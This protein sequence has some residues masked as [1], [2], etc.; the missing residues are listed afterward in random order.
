MDPAWPSL[1]FQA[2]LLTQL[3]RPGHSVY[4]NAMGHESPVELWLRMMS[5]RLIKVP[6]YMCA[7]G[8]FTPLV[9]GCVFVWMCHG[10]G[11]ELDEI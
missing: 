6:M 3:S 8:V 9:C 7:H 5:K 1:L 11:P 4:E 2:L 10:E